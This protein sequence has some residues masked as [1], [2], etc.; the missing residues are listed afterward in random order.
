[1]MHPRT[2]GVIGLLCLPIAQAQSSLSLPATLSSLPNHP[3]WRAADRG[4]EAAQRTV[5]QAKGAAL[6][7]VNVGANGDATRITSPAVDPINRQSANINAS[8]STAVLPWSPAQDAVRSSERNLERAL[9][10]RMEVRSGLWL[11]LSSRFF[12]ARSAQAAVNLA[13]R[14]AD[15]AARRV[16]VAEAQLQAGTGTREAGLQAKQALES[17]RGGVRQAMAQANLTRRLLLSSIGRADGPVVFSADAPTK[18]VLP[19]T[20]ELLRTALERRADVRRAVL[21]VLEAEDALGIATRDRW[22]PQ[23]SVQ[24]G[25][26]GVDTSGQPTGSRVAADLNIPQG[27]F[28]VQGAYGVL[29]EPAAGTSLSLTASISLPVFSPGSDARI[30]AAQANLQAAQA[31]LENVRLNAEADVRRR[32]L[33]AEAAR[34]Q[35]QVTTLTLETATQRASDAGKRLELGLISALERDAALI[36]AAQAQQD[37]ET[38]ITNTHLAALRVQQASALP[39]GGTQ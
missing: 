3:A 15:L 20:E 30:G 22:L 16:Q 27:S 8:L 23:A 1:M 2:L 5:D 9:T 32:I 25:F 13:E 4:V 33:E 34:D 35:V 31:T 28:G 11:E 14:N 39:L 12:E 36:A 6:I 10:D 17:A 19:A 24:L 29:G 37:L 26:G 18:V 21:G 38:S 7:N